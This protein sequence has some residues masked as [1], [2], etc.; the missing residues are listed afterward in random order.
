MSEMPYVKI[1]VGDSVRI[2][3]HPPVPMES[4]VEGTVS[5]LDETVLHGPL[6]VV[7]VSRQVILDRT[8]PIRAGH[9]DYILYE[10]WNDFP[11]QIEVQSTTDEQAEGELTREPILQ[12]L[13]ESAQAVGR[14]LE[15]APEPLHVQVERQDAARRGGLIHTLFRR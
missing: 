2:H 13:D 6:I 11:G 1:A 8:S 12:E 14:A 5:R 9:R 4:F 15:N 7:D 3:F 10:H